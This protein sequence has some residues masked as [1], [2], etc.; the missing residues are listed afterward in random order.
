[1]VRFSEQ[2]GAQVRNDHRLFV[3]AFRNHQFPGL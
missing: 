3:D 1:M 2:Y